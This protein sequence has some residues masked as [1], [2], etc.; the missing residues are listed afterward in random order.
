[1][2]RKLTIE[3]LGDASSFERSAHRSV[4][5]AKKLETQN[6]SLRKGVEKTHHAMRDMT[7]GLV[8]AGGVVFGL[9]SMIETA[10]K[11]EES[12]GH[13]AVTMKDAGL[14]YDAHAKSI[15]GV[16]AKQSELAGFQKTDLRESYAALI[17]QSKDVGKANEDLAL[18]VDIAR[19]RHIDL[20]AAQQ[21]VIKANMGMVG[22]LKRMG[23]EI[24]PVHD[25][26][27]ALTDSHLKFT[28]AQKDAAKALDLAATKQKAISL[29]QKTY[30]GQAEEYG[31]SSA[32]AADKFKVS[33]T[34]LEVTLGTALLPTLTDG[35]KHVSNW[36]NKL[37]DSGDAAKYANDGVAVIK[38]TMAIAVPIVK[39]G[40]KAF[41]GLAHALGSDK[42]AVEALAGAF[43]AYKLTSTITGLGTA[44]GEKGAAGK[45]GLLTTRMKT[46]GMIG[47]VALAVELDLKFKG[48]LQDKFGTAGRVF[49]DLANFGSGGLGDLASLFAGGGGGGGKE[50]TSSGAVTGAAPQ[51]GSKAKNQGAAIAA[52]AA[53]QL[54]ISYQWGGPAIL[55][56]HTDCSGLAQAVLAKNGINV[57]RTTYVQWSQGRPVAPGDLQPGDLV[58]FHMGKQGPEHVGIYI[59]NDQFI[60]DPHTGASVRVSKLSTY[61]GFCGARRYTSTTA[62]TTTAPKPKDAPSVSDIVSQGTK[63]AAKKAPVLTGSKLLSTATQLALADAHGTKGTA[64]DLSALERAKHELEG[65]PHSVAV[66]KELA[67]V[68]GQIHAI[69]TANVKAHLAE[70]AAAYKRYAKAAAA[71]LKGLD[72]EWKTHTAALKKAADEAK[73]IA[74]RSFTEAEAQLFK[75]F[76]RQ[77]QLGLTNLDQQRGQLT[78]TEQKIKDLQDAHAAT[79]RT[80]SLTQAQSDLAT[81]KIGVDDGNGNMVVDPAAVK[82]A[83][84][85]LDAVL[86]DQQLADLQTQAD[87]E[88]AAR[89]QQFSDKAQAYQDQRDLD[90]QALQDWLDDQ[91]TKLDDGRETWDKFYAD[92]KT[93]A[94]QGGFDVGAAFWDAWSQAAADNSSSTKA[95]NIAANP[96]TGDVYQSIQKGLQDGTISQ[97]LANLLRSGHK[98]EVPFLSDG[99]VVTRPTLAVLGESGHEAVVPLSRLG[100]GRDGGGSTAPTL[101]L[102]VLSDRDLAARIAPF[103]DNTGSALVRI[104]VN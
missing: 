40:A 44:A 41:Q 35:L 88:R 65:L 39:D 93:K 33:L 81:A 57:G 34:N 1:M 89:D 8:G 96:G 79:A 20:A 95:G 100:T 36:V 86:Y 47:V 27:N 56:Q 51:T 30:A 82:S 67:T 14:N 80:D 38:D 104:K 12:Q 13:L 58:F 52:V 29:L 78:P 28:T 75:Q 76:D 74:D 48:A 54:G 102:T 53:T 49:W 55:G 101:Q 24:A 71:D 84:A 31:K 22:Q 17:R 85:A 62:S 37:N 11:A 77:T 83:Q 19:G 72:G 97:G 69:E 43:A 4:T 16:I 91:K 87:A 94:A 3:I 10:K 90:R 6:E 70:Q 23:I 64:D 50:S 5:A 32:G 99:G 63:K 21:I 45:V 92:L 9:E 25:A 7:I 2:D 61:P 66:A 103:I 59:G 15:E 98:L 73:A 26:M 68:N 46:L 60:E 18:T 42:K